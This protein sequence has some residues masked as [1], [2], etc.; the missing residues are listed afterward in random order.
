MPDTAAEDLQSRISELERIGRFE[1][2]LRELTLSVTHSVF[3]TLSLP[4][5][6][7]RLCHSAL[8]LFHARHA[9]AWMHDRRARELVLEA[10]SDTAPPKL[11]RVALS[12]EPALAKLLGNNAPTLVGRR[13]ER[14]LVIPLRG[15]RRA[16]GLLLL[17]GL[18][19]LPVGR[20]HLLESAT[21]LGRQISTAIENT[22]LFEDILQSR[23]ELENTFNSLADLVIV[24]DKRGR[25]TN[26]NRA[27][28]QRV[29]AG[30]TQPLD[31]AVAELVG[32]ELG[33]WLS[34]TER[35]G[36]LPAN[37]EEREFDDPVLAGHFS[38]RV[39]PLYGS[40]Q[41][42]QGIVIVA[43]D[44]TD[45]VR[46]QAERVAL[47]ERLVQSEKLAALGQFVAG[48]A[49]E[50]NNPLQGVLGHLELLR[51]TGRVPRT[52]QPELRVV[53]READR[54]ARIVNNLLVFAGSRRGQR[55]RVNLNTAVSR[56][57]ALRARI[58]RRSGIKIVRDLDPALPHVRGDAMLLQ[59]AII[60]I[61][62]NAEH[63]IASVEP[64]SGEITITTRAEG[65]RSRV[66]VEVRDTGPGVPADVLPRIFEPFFTTKAVGEGTGLG[67]ALAYGIVQDHA[68]EISARNDRRGGAVFRIIL[69]AD[70]MEARR[71]SRH[72]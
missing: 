33:K 16:L 53:Y 65:R 58:A 59:Q 44:E 41:T 13:N 17:E 10:S 51:A 6:L 40:D 12:S 56:S 26:A 66:V 57:A 68:G 27:F 67:L 39:T 37:G 45:Q 70:T 18:S 9:A 22:I 25:V 21:V 62:V 64:G 42:A 15:R 63:A 23:A 47:S 7:A 72:D 52:L 32:P 54:A 36:S 24:C 11:K 29:A 49:H 55:R 5:S 20:E 30:E 71:P 8:P 46:L 48:V 2:D 4:T 31:R 14:R 50:L 60:N 19:D 35:P 61:I 1:A 43:R 69:P 28:R 34:E 38:V 3:S